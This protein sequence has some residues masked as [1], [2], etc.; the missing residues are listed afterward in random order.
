M[1]LVLPRVIL[2]NRGDIASRWGVLRSLK[3]LGVDD[4]SVF[5]RSEEDVPDLPYSRLPYGKFRNLWLDA[6]GRRALLHSDVVLWAV[7]LDLQDDSSLAKLFYLWTLFT[8]YR[9]SGLKVCCLFQG[10]GPLTT[11]I[12]RFLAGQVLKQVDQFVTRDPGSQRLLQPLAPRRLKIAL[13]YDAIFLPGFED[14][15]TGIQTIHDFPIQEGNRP[16]IGFNIRQWFHF[17]SSLLP[18]EF[19]RKTYYQRSLPRMRQLMENVIDCMHALRK[20]HDA[21]LLLLSAYQPGIVPWEDDLPWLG[22]LKSAFAHDNDVVLVDQP[23]SMPHYFHLISHLDVMV[24][25]RLHS[26][27]I[28]MRFGVPAINIS[29]T[30]KGRDIYT[31]LGLEKDVVDLQSVLNSS[32]PILSVVER[33]L[34][35]PPQA[36]A[37]LAGFVVE[38]V[39]RNTEILKSVL[40]L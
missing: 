23:L 39:Q 34:N 9:R 26:S 7:G 31:Y 36:K 40:S 8:H 4:V 6:A 15:I 2:G 32:T 10:A 24:A 37:R 35:D 27:L 3:Q 19:R 5:S 17:T 33:V 14:E 21:R 20:K 25:M 11:R 38:A 29:Y 12:G 28:A 16:T 13:G 22:Q 1:K 30:L 18:Y